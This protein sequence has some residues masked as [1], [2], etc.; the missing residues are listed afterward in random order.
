MSRLIIGSSTGWLYAMGIY[1]LRQQEII[2]KQVGASGIEVCLVG[3]SSSDKRIQSLA[4]G[5]QFDSKAFDYRSLHI[6]DVD[7]QDSK[8]QFEIAIRAVTCCG[9]S[10]ALTHPL[11]VNGNYPKKHYKEMIFGGVP[12]AVENMD[13]R[14]DGG[15]DVSELERLVRDVG[16]RFVLDVQHAYEHDHEMEYASDLFESLKERLVHLHVS[17]E[18]AD[19]IHSMIC[20]ALNAKKILEFIAKV[21]SVKNIPLIIEG[22]YTSPDELQQEIEFLTK[23]LC[24]C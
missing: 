3:W 8:H 7:G 13:S 9:A 5:E 14:K 11:K 1:S 20:K 19:N 23:E 15:F 16:C 4:A 12:L 18:T 6:S 2:L 10:V 22:E 21:L 17:G 24:L